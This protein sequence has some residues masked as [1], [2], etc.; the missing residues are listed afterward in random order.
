MHFD[1]GDEP[2]NSG[3][4]VSIFC[5]VNKGDYPID[6]IWLLNNQSI[7]VNN[8]RNNGISLLRTNKRISQ[9][10]IDSVHAEHAG[11]YECLAKNPAGF[12]SLSAI[13]LVNGLYYLHN[14][15][16]AIVF[17]SLALII[18]YPSAGRISFTSHYTV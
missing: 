6:I 1:F 8:I 12:A 15:Y 2:I 5:T 11:N 16:F 3:E 13:L 4:M 9:L 14:N 18:N 17:F 10:S 7:D